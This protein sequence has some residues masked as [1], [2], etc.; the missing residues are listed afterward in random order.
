VDRTYSYAEDYGPASFQV[1]AFS[2]EVEANPQPL[3]IQFKAIEVYS[4]VNVKFK[5]EDQ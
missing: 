4:E 3:D 5:L 2:G 1:R